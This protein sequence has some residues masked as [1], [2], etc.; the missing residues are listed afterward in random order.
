M[1]PKAT[2]K[3][4][5]PRATELGR[6]ATTLLLAKPSELAKVNAWLDAEHSL[7]AISERLGSDTHLASACR[8]HRRQV[9][10][11]QGF[12]EEA[13]AHLERATATGTNE[14]EARASLEDFQAQL[15]RLKTLLAESEEARAVEIAERE[16]R[17]RDPNNEHLIRWREA[18][19]YRRLASAMQEATLNLGRLDA[20]EIHDPLELPEW[21]SDRNLWAWRLLRVMSLALDPAAEWDG[22][23]YKHADESADLQDRASAWTSLGGGWT[24]E[25]AAKGHALDLLE[26]VLTELEAHHV[27]GTDGTA[28]SAEPS[29]GGGVTAEKEQKLPGPRASRLGTRKPPK[30]WIWHRQALEKYGVRD[31]TLQGWRNK[32][33]LQSARVKDED[34]RCW[35]YKTTALEAL[36]R[37]KGRL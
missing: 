16:A 5:A 24:E 13:K 11:F 31:S 19:P 7:E 25:S 4:L 15:E 29:G 33:E 35:R 10:E 27:L 21:E 22:R 37:R 32:L 30:G 18:E 1:A 2:T 26:K 17:L 28:S 23:P 6:R 8:L 34:T 3:G 36:L 9:E 12:V 20:R 14:T